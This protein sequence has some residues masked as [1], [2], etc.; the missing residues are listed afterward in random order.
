MRDRAFDLRAR[1]RG[2]GLFRVTLF[3]GEQTVEP[4]IFSFEKRQPT[5]RKI[6]GLIRATLVP[7]L[8]PARGDARCEQQA[9][10]ENGACAHRVFILARRSRGRA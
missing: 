9:G 3:G 10:Q 8:G 5:E 1:L 2:G 7:R 6:R 4:A